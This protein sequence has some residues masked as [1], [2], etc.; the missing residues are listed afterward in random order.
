LHDLRHQYASFLINQG[1]TLYEVMQIL[2]HSD[3]VHAWTI[4]T[5]SLDG[6][7]ET[8]NPLVEGSSP[9]GPTILTEIMALWLSLLWSSVNTDEY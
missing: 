5:S 2:G 8:H 6:E 3:Q 1:R 9:S 7:R 4:L